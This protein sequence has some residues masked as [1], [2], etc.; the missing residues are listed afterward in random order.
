MPSN[1]VS[2][3]T[4]LDHY[5][6]LLQPFLRDVQWTEICV[7]RPHEVFTEN[8]GGWIRH[9]LSSLTQSYC[10][11]LARLIA[12][13]SKQRID[14]ETPLL[15]A[16]LPGGERVQ[17][18]IPPAVPTG[19]ISITIRKP[20]TQVFSLDDFEAQGLFADCREA[21]AEDLQPDEE[22]LLALLRQKRYREFISVAVQTRKNLIISGAT[23]SGKTT[24]TNGLIQAIPTDERIITIEDALELQLPHHP[25]HVRLLYSRD[26]QGLSKATARSLIEATLRLKP[27]RILLSELRS[28]EAFYFIRNINSGHPGSIT[29]VHANSPRLAFEQLMLLVKESPGGNP[30]SREDIKSLLRLLVDVIIQFKSVRGRGRLMTEIYYDPYAKRQPLG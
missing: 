4:S 30:L 9:E 8:R 28:G 3:A 13:F 2:E 20:S 15:A 19:T 22:E 1:P 14:E 12:N 5:L 10:L 21:T 16:T 25:N 7:N 27:D 11:H 29:T 26:S 6:D 17:I 23:G 18:V 24:F